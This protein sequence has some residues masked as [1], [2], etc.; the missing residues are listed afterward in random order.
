M[1]LALSCL[2]TKLSFGTVSS[3]SLMQK[4]MS[5]VVSILFALSLSG[6]AFAQAAPEKAAGDTPKAEEK[7]P[8]KEK[9]A[10]KVKKAKKAK[11]EKKAEEAAPM[12]D[13]K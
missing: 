13:K 11:T 5:I 6:L 12:P 10:K 9:K 2:A 7:A 8:A 4:L 1:S 3:A